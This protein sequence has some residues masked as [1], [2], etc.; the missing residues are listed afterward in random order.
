MSIQQKKESWGGIYGDISDNLLGE[1][2]SQK[3]E[4][5]VILNPKKSNL[6]ILG[7]LKMQ[8]ILFSALYKGMQLFAFLL[9]C[10]NESMYLQF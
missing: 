2:S 7:T 8:S 10:G 6:F 4:L 9:G 5:I 1:C 3:N